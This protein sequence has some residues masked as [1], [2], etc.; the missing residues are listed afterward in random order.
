MKSVLLHVFEDEALQDRLSVALDV[1]RAHD[2]HL[3]CAYVTPYASY[4]GLD[5]MGG[6]FT[7]GALI[8]SLRATEDRVRTKLEAH[9]AHEDVRWDW[10]SY[11]GDPAQTLVSVSSLTDL[12]VLSQSGRDRVNATSPLSIVDD[13]AVNAGCAVLVVPKGVHQ[14]DAMAPIVIGWN[15]SEQAARAIREAMPALKLATSVTLVSVGEE[16]EDYP[17]T[18][19]SAYLSRHGVVSDLRAFAEAEGAPDTLIMQ[20]AKEVGAGAILIGAFGHSRLRE[21]LLGGVTRRLSTHSDI[22]VLLGR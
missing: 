7:S 3:T 12:V 8:D 2:A 18:D 17:S 6:V 21:T 14:F 4:V 22:P 16:G 20:V 5:P 11:D 13:V 15:A 9:M 1:C 10:Q 19:A